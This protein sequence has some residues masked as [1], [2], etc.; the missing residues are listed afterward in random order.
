MRIFTSA[1]GGGIASLLVFSALWSTFV[2]QHHDYG[3]ESRASQIFGTAV[4][5]GYIIFPLI[6][7]PVLVAVVIL[8]R[9]I[10]SKKKTERP[11][12]LRA[13]TWVITCTL[14]TAVLVGTVVPEHAVSAAL[15]GL[16]AAVVGALAYERLAAV[17]PRMKEANQ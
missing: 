12:I 16:G 11:E 3:G 6:L 14:S 4:F 10:I 17:F 15:C 2:V 13:V 7:V 1:L 9:A 5:F 8:E